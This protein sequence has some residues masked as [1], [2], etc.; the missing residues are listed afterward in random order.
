MYIMHIVECPA[1][2]TLRYLR[3]V[4][5][6]L[7]RFH[8]KLGI[9]YS[10]RPETPENLQELFPDSVE[11]FYVPM[12]RSINPRIDFSAL[13]RIVRILRTVNPDIIHSHSSKAGVLGRAAGWLVGQRMNLYTPHGY[14]FLMQDVNSR[15][16]TLYLLLEKFAAKTGAVTVASSRNEAEIA[17]LNGLG[18]V[19]NLYHFI[20]VSGRAAAGRC[21]SGHSPV[22]G[23]SGRI[24]PQ[25]NPQVFAK[26]AAAL[27]QRMPSARFVWI[28]DGELRG[29]LEKTCTE[30]NVDIT[31]TGWLSLEQAMEQTEALDLYAHTALWEAWPPYTVLEAMAFGVPVVALAVNG[32][33]DAMD[34]TIELV[35]DELAMAEAAWAALT[36]QNHYQERSLRQKEVI[37]E[38]YSVKAAERDIQEVYG[39]HAAG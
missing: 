30:L 37:Y 1:A 38:M 6:I 27:K 33:T 9:I 32:I 15:K 3:D 17:R 19:R 12:C 26:M 7:N 23:T 8:I 20:P 34:G 21:I 4:C 24:S 28:G 18:Q 36:D 39:V 5:E 22:I 11:W 10:L 16:R 14:S 35:R 25:K 2:G 29:E 31:I 13:S